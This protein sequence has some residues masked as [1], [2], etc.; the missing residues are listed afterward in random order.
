MQRSIEVRCPEIVVCG[1]PVDDCT[2]AIEEDIPVTDPTF[3]AS[4]K[5]CPV[6]LLEHIFRP[7]TQCTEMM[8]LF[9]ER[10]QVLREVGVILSKVCI[11]FIYTQSHNSILDG[12]VTMQKYKGSF[13][14]FFEQFQRAHHG[15]G[16]ALQL[17]KLVA[18]TFPPFRD[19]TI[20]NGRRGLYHRAMLLP[21]TS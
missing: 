1:A 14:V 11:C 10:I 5:H 15:R 3:Y 4:E 7:A 6:E 8:P 19:E 13:Q 18:E 20:Y 9:P 16:T 21:N 2:A 17:V 12:R